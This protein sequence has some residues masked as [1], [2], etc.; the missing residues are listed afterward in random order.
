MA[1]TNKFLVRKLTPQDINLFQEL[2]FVFEDVFEMRNFKIPDLNHLQNL[3]DKPDFMAF[4]ALLENKVVGGLTAYI[5]T[6]YFVTSSDVYILDL[7][8]KTEFQRK[9]LGR[10]LMEKTIE[11]CKNQNMNVMFVQADEEDQ[12]AIDFYHSLGGIPGKAIN[13]DYPLTNKK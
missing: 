4:V 2:V 1:S 6:S 3:L 13:F 12:H 9:G 5:L 11:H 7:A 8:I 10:K